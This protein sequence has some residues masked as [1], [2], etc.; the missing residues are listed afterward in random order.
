MSPLFSVRARRI[1]KMSS[2]LRM[3]VALGTSRS[4]ARCVSSATLMSL[5]RARSMT[6]VSPVA[7]SRSG[8]RSAAR[9][10]ARSRSRSLS[11]SL[12]RGG[13]SILTISV[14]RSSSPSPV[15][16]DTGRTGTFS[17]WVHWLRARVRSARESLSIF[18]AMTAAAR[19]GASGSGWRR[20]SVCIHSQ[21]ATSC[22]RPGCRASTTSSAADG[23][24]RGGCGPC[25]A[26]VSPARPKYSSIM[27]AKPALAGSPPRA[28]P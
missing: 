15:S 2:C 4:L 21:A 8:A 6:A 11:R 22:G 27:A 5:S 20:V 13:G 17:C 16:A 23:P 26:S 28:Y 14:H 25:G 1:S 7:A 24:P 12:S 9:S 3:P 18:E 19:D 10:G